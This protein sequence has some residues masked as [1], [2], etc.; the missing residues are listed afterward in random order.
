MANRIQRSE[1]PSCNWW[2]GADVR[3]HRPHQGTVA[4]GH[5]PLNR[6][7]IFWDALNPTGGLPSV[8][9]KARGKVTRTKMSWPPACPGLRCALA[10]RIPHS[11]GREQRMLSN[12]QLKIAA[13]K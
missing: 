11:Y 10:T 9:D 1:T 12:E 8:S 5:C 6:C 3:I 2:Q 4:H 7:L 13:D